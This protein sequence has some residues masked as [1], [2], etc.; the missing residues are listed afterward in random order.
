MVLLAA[1]L[2]GKEGNDSVYKKKVEELQ[3]AL[4]E[5]AMEYEVKVWHCQC[6]CI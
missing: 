6:I 3:I 1:L 5:C 2:Q 4:L